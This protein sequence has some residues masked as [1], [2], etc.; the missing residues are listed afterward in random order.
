MTKK[1]LPATSLDAYK[2]LQADQLREIYQKIIEALKVLGTASTEQISEYTTLPHPKI[3]KRVSEMERLEIIFRP[4]NR[5]ATKSGRTAFVWCLC[6]NQPK[7]QVI[8]RAMA[9]KGIADYSREINNISKAVQS[10]M[11]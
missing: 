6:N 8:E 11:F 1:K 5:V 4:G 7:T 9:G 10:K 3:H 2:S